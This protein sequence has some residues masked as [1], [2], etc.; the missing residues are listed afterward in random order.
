MDFL[1]TN[2]LVYAVSRRADDLA[3]AEA[4]RRLIQLGGQFI[5]LQVLQE[6]YRVAVHPRKL[7][8]THDEVVILCEGWRKCFT[9]LEPTLTLFD[10]SLAICARYQISYFDACILA[11][12]KQLGCSTVYS[13]DLNDG[14]TYDGLRVVNPFIGL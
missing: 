11:A 7:N 6:F 1:D 14:Q 12:A 8:Y 13:E 3:K 4:A 10:E 2:V 9:V 5:S